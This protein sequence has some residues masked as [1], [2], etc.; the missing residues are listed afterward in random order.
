MNE[1]GGPVTASIQ[2]VSQVIDLVTNVVWTTLE[3]GKLG[4]GL[5]FPGDG[6]V[7]VPNV[8]DFEPDQAFSYGE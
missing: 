8:G 3:K 5:L 4:L 2:G 6:K 7:Q 1:G